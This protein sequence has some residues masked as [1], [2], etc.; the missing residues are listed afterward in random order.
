MTGGGEILR[1]EQVYLAHKCANPEQ[2]LPP[3]SSMTEEAREQ[4]SRFKPTDV[5]LQVWDDLCH[6]ATTL[7]FTRPAKYMYRS[8]AQFGAWALARAQKT[9]IEILDDDSVSVISISSAS[10]E[11]ERDNENGEAK[12]PAEPDGTE[13]EKAEVGKAGDPLPRFKNHMIRQRV[14]RHGVISPLAPPSELPGCMMARELVGVV[15]ETPVRRWLEVRAQW[16]KRYGSTRT[17]IHKRR[18]KEM[19]AGYV[20]FDGETP[21]PA[22]LAG[23]RK[24]SGD[25]AEKKKV[26]SMGLALW[27]L[28]GSKHD[29]ATM[30]REHGMD[31]TPNTKATTSREGEGARSPS[32]IQAQEED[33]AR[34]ELKANRRKSRTKIV[35]DLNQAMEDENPNGNTEI[36]IL[37]AQREGKAEQA[38]MHSRESSMAS[39]FLPHRMGVAGKRPIV[40]GIAV[41]FSLDKDAETASMITLT[42]AM[43]QPGRTA[44]PLPLTPTT[45]AFITNSAAAGAVAT[46][47]ARDEVI[48]PE[49]L[50]AQHIYMSRADPETPGF[51]DVFAT[52]MGENGAATPSLLGGGAGYMERPRMQTFVT[53]QEDLPTQK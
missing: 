10:S 34:D 12:T 53:A 18:L 14:D 41:P 47:E 3:E 45:D 15:K 28:W 5:Q 4:L 40:G 21:P 32:D 22:A 16:N 8:I 23:R 38:G 39:G 48:D 13:T 35:R 25:S 9:D 2:Y 20:G 37:M 1:D 7:S 50:K 24:A 46:G 11:S 19:A 30:H 51:G 29:E 36:S 49:A 17:K 42:S 27:S 52:P 6:V 43:D 26:K 44:S 33:I 31:K